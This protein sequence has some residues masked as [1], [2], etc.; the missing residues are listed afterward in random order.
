MMAWLMAR[1]V[2]GHAEA[3]GD[4]ELAELARDYRYRVARRYDEFHDRHKGQCLRPV[5]DLD[6]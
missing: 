1:R 5:I 4:E 3:E 6:R 2:L